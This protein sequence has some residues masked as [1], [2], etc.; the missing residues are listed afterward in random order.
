MSEATKT[1]GESRMTPNFCG[2]RT[3]DSGHSKGR[4]KF[5]FGEIKLDARMLLVI[6][7]H[8]EGFSIVIMH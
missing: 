7:I 4:E 2:I 3:K 5:F 1:S 8:S 6:L